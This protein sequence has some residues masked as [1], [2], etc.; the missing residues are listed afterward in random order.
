MWL[1][2]GD[3]DLYLGEVRLTADFD[4][5]A[6]ITPGGAT[7]QE[8]KKLCEAVRHDVAERFGIEINP[9]VNIR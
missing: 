8:V 7:G 6:L 2:A 5:T 1:E 4:L 9:E 3:F